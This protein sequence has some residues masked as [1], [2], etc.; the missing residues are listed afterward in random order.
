M[1]TQQIFEQ[2]AAGTSQ[3]L[4]QE[5]FLKK[6][7]SGKKLVIKLGMDPTAPD[8]H[9]G[10]AVVLSKLRQFQDFGHTI[11]YII[12]DFTARIGDP[13]G[14]SKTRPALTH[15]QVM[16]NSKTY[17]NQVGK[18]LD[19]SKIVVRYNSEWLNTLPSVEWVKLC[20]QV[21]LARLIERE[22]FAN[23]M[24]AHQPIGFHELLYPLMQ[25]YDSVVLNAD[26][27]LGGTDQT[28]NNLMG[29]F[30]QEQYG[31]KD[32]QVVITL[33]ILEGLDGVQKMS[34]SYGNS[35]G[36]AESADQAYGKLMSISDT[37]MWRYY[38]LLLHKT[39]QQIFQLQ[40]QHPMDAKKALA[41]AVIERFWS[42]DDA[43]SAQDI[44]E[45][46]FQ[47][48]NFSQVQEFSMPAGV[49]NALTIVE[50]V[51]IVEPSFSLTEIRRLIVAGAVKV[52]EV[53]V[54][55]I[56]A[57]IAWQPGTLIKIGKHT[58]FKLT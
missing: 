6:L 3:I 20:A 41:F 15:E 4:P 5:H 52:D 39:A 38:A 35:I 24:A 29:R 57:I 32:P 31:N 2:L 42:F 50:L 8:L 43:Q 7:A 14:R 40:Q 45:N 46:L 16:E 58:F 54:I 11:I 21:T 12:G 55:D 27:E 49:L 25:G 26:V 33:P 17:L 10:H 9:L 51:K 18:I 13:T 22:D 37:L 28:F 56:H 47:K 34:K 23:R 44:F 30:L 53:K 48:K 1:N 36:L 19:L